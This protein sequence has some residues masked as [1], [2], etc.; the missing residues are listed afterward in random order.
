[1]DALA[2]P[3]GVKRRVT[4]RFGLG[5]RHALEVKRVN[6]VGDV[7]THNGEHLLLALEWTN[8]LE[9]LRYDADMEVVARAVQVNDLDLSIG[10]GFQHF[11]FNPRFV[12]H[13]FASVVN[14]WPCALN[15][16]VAA[17]HADK[18]SRMESTA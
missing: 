7:L 16:I 11:G 1:M 18:P 12:D 3:V 9:G 5:W 17:V 4:R 6:R 10:D 8:A 2:T 13:A 15:L 14:R